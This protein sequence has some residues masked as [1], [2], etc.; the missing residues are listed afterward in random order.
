MERVS[1]HAFGDSIRV[2]F[3]TDEQILHIF[4]VSHG[5]RQQPMSQWNR[6][7]WFCMNLIL[8]YVVRLNS[9]LWTSDD[10][11]DLTIRDLL[12]R[13]IDS[14]APIPDERKVRRKWHFALL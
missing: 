1:R 10:C 5:E 2:S 8:W 13:C 14:R 7:I 3:Q 12:V 4:R 6:E 9:I 11:H